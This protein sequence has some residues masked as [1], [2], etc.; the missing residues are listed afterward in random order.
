M[1]RPL[2]GKGGPQSALI[3]LKGRSK[4]KLLKETLR[5]TERRIRNFLEYADKF[6]VD[7]TLQNL[8]DGLAKTNVAKM[9]RICDQELGPNQPSRCFSAKYYT[10]D[11]EPLFFYL[12][13][14]WQDGKACV[15]KLVQYIQTLYLINVYLGRH[16][17]RR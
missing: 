1:P 15:S 3:Y 16:C 10:K 17:L 13:E 4:Q 5:V 12:G 11:D 7:F 8:V 9:E 2:F 14:R 6:R